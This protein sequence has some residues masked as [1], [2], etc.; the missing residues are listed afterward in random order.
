MAKRK[1][2][3]KEKCGVDR[4]EGQRLMANYRR[5]SL[6]YE[7]EMLRRALRPLGRPDL[8]SDLGQPVTA[9]SFNE[10]HLLSRHYPLYLEVRFNGASNPPPTPSIKRLLEL[11]RMI[12]EFPDS[13]FHRACVHPKVF[14]PSGDPRGFAVVFPYGGG[15]PDLAQPS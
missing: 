5:A 2:T 13:E 15:E 9:T 4:T 7:D 11:E 12:F 6:A 8:L 10:H 1:K 14:A 3:K